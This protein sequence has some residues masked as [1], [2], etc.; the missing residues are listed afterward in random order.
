MAEKLKL[1]AHDAEDLQI[2]SACLQDAIC[3]VGDMAYQPAT[4]RFAVIFNRFCWENLQSAKGLRRL[5]RP[6]YK[7]IRT[8]IHFNTV[9]IVRRRGID[10][11]RPEQALNLLA[12]DSAETTDKRMQIR[13]LFAGGTEILLEAECV[14]C[15]MEDISAPWTV[16]TAPKHP[17]DAPD[18]PHATDASG[19][20]S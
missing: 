5:R 2:I 16:R 3:R 12:I 18:A 17:A 7:R 6:R 10:Q 9:G 1:I 4:R 8:A 11:F 19:A 13:L 14:D 20:P 15:I